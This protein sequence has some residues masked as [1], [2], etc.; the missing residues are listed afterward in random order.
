M[1]NQL[2]MADVEAIIPLNRRGWYDR[3]IARKLGVHRETFGRYVRPAAESKPANRPRRSSARN[4]AARD[5]AL[6]L[7]TGRLDF[8][9]HI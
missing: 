3:R 6:T 1:A 7:R 4:S 9:R 2:K 8:L 5:S